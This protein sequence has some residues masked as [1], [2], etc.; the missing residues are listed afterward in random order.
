MG[1]LSS[2]EGASCS[3]C[4]GGAAQQNA[5]LHQFAA[6]NVFR[7]KGMKVPML[8]ERGEPPRVRKVIGALPKAIP[9]LAVDEVDPGSDLAEPRRMEDVVRHFHRNGLNE[10]DSLQQII[11]A[12]VMS[13]A[14]IEHYGNGSLRSRAAARAAAR[15]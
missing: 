11:Y 9:F 14:A 12:T 4:F 10:L 2:T 1:K 8:E 6:R 15:W 5:Q 7:G 3:Y 13:I